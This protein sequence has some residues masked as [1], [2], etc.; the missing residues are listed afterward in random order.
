MADSFTMG[1][2]WLGV[3]IALMCWGTFS[4]LTK[5]ARMRELNVQAAV[6]QVRDR[7]GGGD[8]LNQKGM[9]CW[10]PPVWFRTCGWAPW[11]LGHVFLPVLYPIFQSD[12]L[13][14]GVCGC[15]GGGCPH[16]GCAGG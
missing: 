7:G 4:S 11:G 5:T 10:S 9:V 15:C 6:L 2:G 8:A 13:D 3:L 14:R 12:Q 1:V 16:K